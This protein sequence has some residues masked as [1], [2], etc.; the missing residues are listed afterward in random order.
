M[1]TPLSWTA[2]KYAKHERSSRWYS[3][4]GIVV[5]T[6]ITYGIISGNMLLSLIVGLIA[7]LYLIIQD[8]DHALHTITIHET[9]VEYDGQFYGWGDCTEF[10][11][12]RSPHY[13]EL[14]IALKSRFKGDLCIQTGEMDPYLIRDRLVEGIPQTV[15]RKEKI[16]D[17]IIRFCKL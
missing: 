5:A 4:A 7:G 16:L 8:A 3:V 1:D 9:G 6:A 17:A 12:L 14:H 10:W 11:I 15:Q 13:Y 2:P